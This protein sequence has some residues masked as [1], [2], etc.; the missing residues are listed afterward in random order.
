MQVTTFNLFRHYL[1]CVILP[2]VVLICT[3]ACSPDDSINPYY[4]PLEPPPG[5]VTIPARNRSFQQGS[6]GP[7]SQADE[8][9]VF[10]NTFQYDFCMDT[11]EITI[12]DYQ[13][14]MNKL[15]YRY[16]STAAY[17]A[18]WPVCFITWYD[19]VLYCN[20]RSLLDGFDT[21]YYYTGVDST[22]TGM[23]YRLHGITV[24]LQ[25]A[26]YRLPTEAEWE[27]AAHAG[28]ASDYPWG[29]S[30]DSS[31]A[32]YHAWYAANSDN[33]LH[34]VARHQKNSFGLYDMAGNAM[35]WVNDVKGTYPEQQTVNF[36]GAASSLNNSRP[37]KGGSFRHPIDKLRI[38]NRNDNYETLSSTSVAYIGFRCAFG[39]F[40]RK[41]FSSSEETGPTIT[42]P[43]LTLATIEPIISTRNA[44]FV[45]VNL[46][47]RSQTLCFIDFS[48]PDPEILQFTDSTNVFNPTIS[49]D[50]NWVAYATRDDGAVDQSIICIRALSLDNRAVLPL[51]DK[52]AFT[53][54]WWIDPATNDT[55][56]IY[57]NSAILNSD[58]S[59]PGTVTKMQKISGGQPIGPPDLLQTAGGYHD[60]RSKDGKYLA[61]GYDRLKMTDLETGECRT[62]FTGPHNGKETGD[63][64]QVCN[65]SITPGAATP[66]AVLFLD[67]GHNASGSVINHPYGVHQYLFVA[68]FDNQIR[69]YYASPRGYVWSHPEW[70]NAE[71][72][73]AVAIEASDGTRSSAGIINLKTGCYRELLKGNNLL[74]PFLWVGNPDGLQVTNLITDS[75][76]Y[77]NE[78]PSIS[79]QT[80][81]SWKMSLFW[82]YCQQTDIFIVGSSRVYHGVCPKLLSK[83]TALNLGASGADFQTSLQL[84]RNYLFN[85]CAR[86]KL[87][88]IE[89]MLDWMDLENGDQSWSPGI[90]NSRGYLYDRNHS[91]WSDSLPDEFTGLVATAP[92]GP[93][94]SPDSL[95]G[96]FSYVQ[97]Q[98]WG[99]VYPPLRPTTWTAD[100]QTCIDN[101]K[102]LENLATECADNGIQLVGLIMPQSPR[103]RKIGYFG[104]YGATLQAASDIIDRLRI[105]EKNNRFFHLY[106]AHL[107]GL[108]D[109]TDADA[110]N[111]DHLCEI[112]AYKFTHRFDSLV[113]GILP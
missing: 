10:T 8:R 68:G 28:L 106:D 89:L 105:I 34:P 66:A 88:G 46:I 81:L 99:G 50:G 51:P 4:P 23:V 22:E 19:A 56:I 85:H 86:I 98:G 53:P 76:G 79:A 101:L 107:N 75:A 110:A 63:T 15:P 20:R 16:E 102:A 43:T 92:N 70:S 26:G 2:P 47:R 37:V 109:Y 93:P 95:R 59:W 94:L 21:V 108:H 33:S 7:L 29:D 55:F 78:P 3:P 112:G 62:L 100:T 65:V 52:P 41:T 72:L 77:Y 90:S 6:N 36:V 64:S 61:T 67:F 5:M 35:E 73:A 83:Y 17:D 49:P 38:A 60:G 113:N 12:A 96:Y 103:Y 18:Q 13:R 27:F 97:V 58:A 111:S 82:K 39:P 48:I 45:F 104:R 91:F 71:D 44:K 54:R 87:I 69:R 30:S 84:I 57:T 14:V 25:T 24:N 31:K 42:R 74:F 80:I 1:Y 32:D 11:T 9:P 40:D